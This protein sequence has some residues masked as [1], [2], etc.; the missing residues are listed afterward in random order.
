[1][2]KLASL[3][4]F[5]SLLILLYSTAQDASFDRSYLREL[6]MQGCDLYQKGDFDGARKC[7]E[8]IV[9]RGIRNA[10]VYFNLGNA[11]FKN[12][13]VGKAIAC[14]RRAEVLSPHDRDIKANL[15]VARAGVVI[16][17]KA[18]SNPSK[19]HL[20]SSLWLLSPRQSKLLIYIFAYLLAS[21]LVAILFV[22]GSLRN[23]LVKVMVALIISLLFFVSLGLHQRSTLK[24]NDDAVLIA[25]TPIMA[26][27]G[28]A[29]E[30]IGRLSQGVEVRVVSETG[31]WV[32]VRLANGV[33][34]WV[35]KDAVERIWE[36][37]SI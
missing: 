35:P 34:G 3:A 15:E 9:E 6:F 28:A 27:P 12:G 4:L 11:Y 20:L 24:R 14:Y 37:F 31:I 33:V 10:N 21:A 36:G 32:E 26:G 23:F 22:G 18:T 1:M 30:E 13:E 5:V 2:G 7:F 25:S 17:D 16:D 19:P 8:T 29:F